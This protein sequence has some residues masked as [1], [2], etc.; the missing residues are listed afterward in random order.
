MSM[1]LSRASAPSILR[2]P[3][4]H[5]PRLVDPLHQRLVQDVVHEGGLP[6]AGDAGDG[7]ETP[8]RHLHVDVAQIVLTG[9][10]DRDPVAPGLAAHGRHGDLP[11]AREV[12]AGDRRLAL[13]Q[14]LHAARAH[15]LAAV[16]AGARPDVDDVVGHTDRLLVVLHDED[17]VAEV[18]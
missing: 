13:E 4:G 1:T 9:T 7:D 5:E 14:V 6:G 16:L 17:G 2:M 15:D 12:L 10:P 18:A 3:A 11:A 8:E